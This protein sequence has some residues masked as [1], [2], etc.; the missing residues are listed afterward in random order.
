[1]PTPEPSKLK[2]S[3]L[4]KKVKIVSA[5][6]VLPAGR[7]GVFWPRVAGSSAWPGPGV[8]LCRLFSCPVLFPSRS[9]WP[10]SCPAWFLFRGLWAVAEFIARTGP[11]SFLQ[12]CPGTLCRL[13]HFSSRFSASFDPTGR[14]SLLVFPVQITLGTR[15]PFITT[16]VSWP[17]FSNLRLFSVMAASIPRRVS[18]MLPGSRR[19]IG[20]WTP[21]W[22]LGEF[23]LGLRPRPRDNLCKTCVLTGP[24]WPNL[25]SVGSRRFRRFLARV[26]RGGFNDRVWSTP[27][28]LLVSVRFKVRRKVQVE[29]E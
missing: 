22:L 10:F 21:D 28:S 26:S 23:L 24:C 4:P 8:F 5:R 15:R 11:S 25:G 9:L 14:R 16:S 18:S 3:V 20:V 2:H 7:A 12:V 19:R 29:K 27:L 6:L 13:H 1:M 17:F